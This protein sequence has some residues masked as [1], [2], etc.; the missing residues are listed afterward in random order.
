VKRAMWYSTRC[1]STRVSSECSIPPL[2]LFA[3]ASLTKPQQV[4][5]DY[6][7][8]HA[9]FCPVCVASTY[10]DSMYS[11]G[12]GLCYGFQITCEL[13]FKVRRLRYVRCSGKRG[14]ASKH[15]G[16]ALR[17]PS[18][19]VEIWWHGPQNPLKVSLPKHRLVAE[20]RDSKLR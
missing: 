7:E 10:R 4:N 13:R 19:T 12:K 17:P 3:L 2:I 9:H 14:Y 15:D 16:R 8:E 6:S 20:H 11:Q 18:T 5:E 1:A